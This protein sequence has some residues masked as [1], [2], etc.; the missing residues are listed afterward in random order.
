MEL[1]HANSPQVIT[2]FMQKSISLMTSSS[3]HLYGMGNHPNDKPH[4][5][6]HLN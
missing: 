5:K 1:L 6:L 4:E 2:L 3:Q